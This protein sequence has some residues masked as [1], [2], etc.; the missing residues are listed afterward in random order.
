[1]D[2]EKS[3]HRRPTVSKQLVS[4]RHKGNTTHYDLWTPFMRYY[5]STY[6]G[7]ISRVC[8]LIQAWGCRLCFS[9]TIPQ[10][11]ALCTS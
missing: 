2:N 7:Y 1:V 5:F 10:W 4:I 11:Q 3:I 8:T 9:Q 6:F